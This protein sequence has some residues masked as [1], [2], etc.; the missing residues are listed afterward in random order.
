MITLDA[1]VVIAYL[2]QD[3]AHHARVSDWLSA[4]VHD[5][6]ATSV[7]TLA[8]VLVRP[9]AL[10]HASTAHRALSLLGVTPI[11]AVAGDE[12]EIAAVRAA[13][14]LRLPDA[15]VIH[16]AER[17]GGGLSTTDLALARAAIARG[18]PVHDLL[19]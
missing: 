15:I 11:E 16:T 13:T 3:D 8:E 2:N 9:S 17:L 7:I 12:L 18:I 6:Y 19:A 5:E 1:G 14:R 10:G 4:H